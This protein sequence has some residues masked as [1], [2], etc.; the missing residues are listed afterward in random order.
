M[1]LLTPLRK[2]LSI[3]ISSFMIK[4]ES[5]GK[6]SLTENHTNNETNMKVIMGKLALI[7]SITENDDIEINRCFLNGVR[8]TMMIEPEEI[9]SI[10]FKPE[11][12][13]RSRIFSIEERFGY[14]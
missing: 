11:K 12:P 8:R 1:A 2:H 7:L 10:L 3:S 4:I 14:T 13:W 5:P 6:G 9:N